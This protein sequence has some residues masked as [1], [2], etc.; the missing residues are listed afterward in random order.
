M[1][2]HKIRQLTGN[3]EEWL[4]TLLRD[5]QEAAIFL[6]VAFEEFQ[7]DSNL[8]VLLLALRYIAEAQAL[9]IMILLANIFRFKK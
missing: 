2:S 8:E 6:Q 3:Y 4:I 7:Q 1:N 5:K 9:N